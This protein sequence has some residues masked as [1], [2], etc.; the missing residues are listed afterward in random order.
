MKSYGP[1]VRRPDTGCTVTLGAGLEPAGMR[2]TQ[3]CKCVRIEAPQQLDQMVS[4]VGDA[5]VMRILDSEKPSLVLAMLLL[6]GVYV[7]E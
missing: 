6:G 7:Q 1:V 3:S 2:H 5:V 4:S